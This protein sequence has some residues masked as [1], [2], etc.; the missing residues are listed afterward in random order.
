MKLV[1]EIFSQGEELVG[2][3][4]VDTNAAWLSGQ[5][6]ELGFRV[7]RHTAVGDDLAAL[8][9]LF[10]EIAGRADCCICTGGL[11]PTL[12][13]LTAEAVS[14]ATG[15]SLEF[16]L[17][18]WEQIQSYF[19]CR[20]RPTPASNRKQALLPA[21]ALRIDNPV[22]TAPG[23]A[24]CYQRCW[25]VFLP[26]VPAEMQA[27]Y[28]TSIKPLLMARFV[29]EPDCL[30]TF[31]SIGIG[32]SAIQQ[33]L[34]DLQ[35]PAEVQLGFRAG[36]NEVQ[37]KL[38]F[39]AGFAEPVK[40]ALIAQ[41]AALIGDYVF[42][43]DGVDG[44]QGDLLDVID[45]QMQHHRYSLAVLETL[46]QGLLS[47]QCLGKSW[48]RSADIAVDLPRLAEKW[49]IVLDA[50]HLEAAA[51]E[52]AGMMHRC[53]H[54]DLVLV[55]LY[56]GPENHFQDRRQAVVLYNALYDGETVMTAQHRV[57]GT[58]QQKQNQATQLTLDLL[59]RF[60]QNTCP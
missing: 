44:I 59:R 48:L 12:D 33:A 31:K 40:Q 49:Q 19:G 6:L 38:L 8:T 52:L 3:Q 55:Q 51:T 43:I 25:F 13:D 24:L 45:R 17:Q 7:S 27:M 36:I 41:T 50:E 22:G 60:L 18:A 28:L 34:H 54:T 1:A 23:F 21:T 9:A 11:G 35:L 2:G 15:L 46:T 5:L 47:S 53:Y 39:P 30:V 32:E 14:L 37:T 42:A 26:G 16:D 10:S 20:S 58:P 57:A 4:I 56:A 29:L